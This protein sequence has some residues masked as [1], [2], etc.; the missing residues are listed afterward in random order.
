MIPFSAFLIAYLSLFIFSSIGELVL[1]LINDR[2]VKKYGNDVPRAFEGLIDG[3]KLSQ[4]NAYNSD[5]TKVTLVKTIISKSVF[6]LIILSG[7]LPWFAE[8]LKD[9]HFI[10]AGLIFFAILGLVGAFMDLPFDYYHIFRIEERYGFN[11]RTLKIWISDL[12]KS[13]TIAVILGTV[14]LSA[15]LL[16]IRYAGNTWWLWAWAIFFSFQLLMTVL[17]PTVI[18][19]IFNKFTA[20]ENQ[21]LVK[22]IEEL[23]EREGLSIK[24]IFQMDEGRRSRHT[25]AYFTGLG[26]VKRIVLYDTL[27]AAHNEDEIL[28]ILAHEIGH[29]KKDHIKKQLIIMSIASIVMLYLASKM[30][31]WE[32]MYSGFGF[33]LMPV[34]VGLFL[35]TVLWEPVTF[36]LSPIAMAISRRFEHDADRYASRLLTSTQPF[37]DALKKLAR[38]N[39]SNL[40]PHP[41]YVR[42]NYSHPPLL[43]RIKKLEDLGDG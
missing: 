25:N 3:E 27:L 7:I 11:K 23:S 19:P 17:Y 36:F 14:L 43:E 42:F 1:D 21:E 31:T 6:L 4:I 32:I 38:D 41:I 33:S 30:I 22:K 9:L 5:L 10:P 13:L 20:I 12:L 24:G 28:A 8:I 16:M 40:R 34:Y 26:K 15:L 37:I 35:I 29:L 18:A 39:L 2:H